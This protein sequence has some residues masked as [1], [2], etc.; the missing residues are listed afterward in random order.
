MP[1]TRQQRRI[2]PLCTVSFECF[3]ITFHN[4]RTFFAIVFT[5]NDEC[6]LAF[7]CVQRQTD[8]HFN[9]LPR[10]A[11]MKTSTSTASARAACPSR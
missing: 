3:T 10:R 6:L 9:K 11:K 7:D 1:K 5:D 4:D 2:D 8:K